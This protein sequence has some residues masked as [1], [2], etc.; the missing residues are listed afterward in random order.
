[1]LTDFAPAL[2]ALGVFRSLTRMP[3]ADVEHPGARK[4]GFFGNGLIPP[5]PPTQ[6]HPLPPSFLARLER[7][8][9]HV[10]AFHENKAGMTEHVS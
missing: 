2:L 6:T 5:A 3:L 7:Q 4:A 8:L 1:M 9:S 10:F